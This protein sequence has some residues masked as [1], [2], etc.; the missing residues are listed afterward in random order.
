M[1]L[2]C[3]FAVT[4]QRLCPLPPLGTASVMVGAACELA[5]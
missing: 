3:V 2:P 4:V 1:F 5:E